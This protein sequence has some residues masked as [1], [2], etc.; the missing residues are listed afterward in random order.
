MQSYF[1]PVYEQVK[2]HGIYIDR[3]HS[4]IPP[5]IRRWTM[6]NGQWTMDNGQWTMDN[7][8]WTM[9]KKSCEE[10]AIPILARYWLDNG[11]IVN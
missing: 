5:E 3:A 9:D 11:T 7:G 2:A 1:A 10:G 6:D 8:Q 4:G